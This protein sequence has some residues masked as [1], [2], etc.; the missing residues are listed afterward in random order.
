MDSAESQRGFES[1]YPLLRKK[2]IVYFTGKM[3][4]PAEDFADEVIERVLRKISEGENIENINAF[5][6]GV[7]RFVFLEVCRKPKTV[8]I[9]ADGGIE[10]QDRYGD[11]ISVVPPQLISRREFEPDESIQ[12]EC[13]RKALN[14][15]PQDK[16]DLLLA[17]YS[18]SENSSNYIERRRLLAESRGLRLETLYTS[19]CRLRK[20]LGDSINKCLAAEQ[21]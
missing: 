16:K 2:L 8:A 21:K 3:M 12:S 4:S 7:A 17:Y 15:L 6:Y 5:A 20:K 18:I 9:A 10:V 1:E 19:V 14:Q 11:K 13:L